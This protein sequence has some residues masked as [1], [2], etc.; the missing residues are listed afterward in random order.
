MFDLLITSPL[1][2]KGDLSPI[3][4]KMGKQGPVGPKSGTTMISSSK[5]WFLQPTRINKTKV[6]NFSMLF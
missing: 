1:A 3:E 6:E 5:L 2:N 4:E